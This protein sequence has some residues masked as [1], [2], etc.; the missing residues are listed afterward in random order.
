VPKNP[1]KFDYGS[2]ARLRLGKESGIDYDSKERSWKTSDGKTVAYSP[3][4]DSKKYDTKR[5]STKAH[6]K[7]MMKEKLNKKDLWRE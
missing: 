7:I 6:F 3:M 5:G 2:A 1:P 4:E